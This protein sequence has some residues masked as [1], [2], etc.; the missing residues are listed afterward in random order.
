MVIIMVMMVD[1]MKHDNGYV[2]GD[3]G[4]IDGSDDYGCID[5]YDND[6]DY[7]GM[8]ILLNTLT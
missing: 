4:T 2:G 1:V 5:G 3:Y 7:Y 8:V 6:G